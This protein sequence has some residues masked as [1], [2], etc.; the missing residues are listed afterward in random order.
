MC[1]DCSKA[2]ANG[3][4]KVRPDPFTDDELD[5][6]RH[7]RNVTDPRKLAAML[8]AWIKKHMAA[9]AWP[10]PFVFKY[11]QEPVYPAWTYSRNL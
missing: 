2:Y 10:R 4:V 1:H 9:V 8:P 6:L 3:W 5:R 7:A 11:G